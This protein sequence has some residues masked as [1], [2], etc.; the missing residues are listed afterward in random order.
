M[1][2]SYCMTT[3]SFPQPI[4]LIKMLGP[5]F[6]ILAL[7]LGSGEVILW[8]YLTANYGLGIIWGALLG[9][10]CQ[11]FINMEIERYALVKGESVFSGLAR[12]WGWVPYWFILSTFF[13][14]ALPGIAAASAQIF[15]HLLGIQD[16]RW[17]AIGILLA[18]GAILTF[19]QSVYKTL[20]KIT[21]TILLVGIPCLLIL[22]IVLAKQ[23]DWL[24][25]WY[26]L[27]GHGAG[28]RWLPTGVSLATFLAAFAY[29]G[30]GGNL[31][32]SQSIYIK[33]KGYGMGRYAQKLGGL[34][35]TNQAQTI[36]LSG[37]DFTPNQVNLQRFRQWWK[38]VSL[39]HLLVFWLL[40]FLSM[41]L[42]MILSYSTTFGLS[43]NLQGL[44]FILAEGRLVGQLTTPLI[45]TAFLVLLGL[46][47]AQTQLGVL[48]STSRIMSENAAL[49]KLKNS[50][51]KRLNLSKI[52]YRFLWGQITFGIILFLLNFYEPK[53]LIITGAIV[54]ALA[55]FVHIALVNV[56]NWKTLPV[57][58][59]P[60][61]PRRL[62]LLII[63]L[64]FAA[65]GFI[66][67]K[68][69]L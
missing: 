16:F 68:S 8:P 36:N 3:K 33:D 19:N 67:L 20:E 39:E 18:I 5:S 38:R 29:S 32:L 4:S 63:F 42:L 51:D 9:L 14:W 12:L 46:M 56:G 60:S 50:Q 21:K 45:G 11:Y 15:G 10:T 26:G 58:T 66:T 54:N 6:V 24:A 65:F 34:F 44:S 28:Y 62:I 2:Q 13:G 37:T 31:N 48:D 22:A 52:Y 35:T 57:A 27:T 59:R 17:L 30:A 7:G 25:L 40:G 49:L 61:W 41:T 55:M 43:D 23:T 53:Q 69:Y 64:L 1:L 47:L